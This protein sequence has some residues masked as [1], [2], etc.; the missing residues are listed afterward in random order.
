MKPAQL[1]TGADNREFFEALSHRDFEPIAEISLYEPPRATIDPDKTKSWVMRSWPIVRSHRTMW[2]GSMMMS[3][4][5]LLT[6]VQIP[7]ILGQAIN[8]LHISGSLAGENLGILSQFAVMLVI[9]I[10]VREI[11]NYTGR[12]MLLTTAY[13][14]EYDLRNNVYEHYM[15]LSFPFYDSVQIGQLISRA[16]S[17]VRSVQQYLVMAPTVFVQCAVVLIAFAEMFMINIPLT[18]V[19]M[20][21]LPITLAVGIIMRKKIF[22]VSWVIQAR[23]AE[24]ATI[25]EENISGVRV[26]KSFAAEQPELSALAGTADRLRWAYIKDADIRGTWA[27]T[28]ENLPR[29]GLAIILLYGGILVIHGHMGVGTLFT[30]Q[31]YMLLFQP[32]F[33]QL[34]MIIMNGQRASASAKRI[35]EVLD[36]QPEIVDRKDARDLLSC[37]G[38]VHF[39]DVSFH[40]A[41][42]TPV[43]R[44]FDL[45][46]TPGE[47]VALVGRT[48]S[49]KSTVARLLNRSYDVSEGAITIDGADIRDFTIAS[50]RAN[51]GI[52]LDEPFLFSVSIRDNIAYGRPDATMDEVVAAAKAADAHGFISRLSGGYE[53]IVGERGYT[54]SGGQRQRIA[55]ARTLLLNPPVLVLDDATS[56]ID[57]QVEQ[58]IHHALAGLLENRTTIIIA[59][60]LATISLADRVVLVENGTV[61]ASGPHAQLLANDRR[62]AEVLARVLEKEGEQLDDFGNRAG[63]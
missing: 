36:H 1:L 57:V 16:N 29:V 28:L 22:P 46:V 41:D 37:R 30:F 3:F 34:G 55:I 61:I 2:I 10:V 23:L 33:R 18:L 21:S 58:R 50:L 19:T 31:A 24:V 40:Y 62:Y 45:V 13:E 14:F 17:D 43:L 12:R 35:Y 6:Q 20:L 53:S 54:L 4:I 56:A 39:R 60:R 32:P 48:G 52:V 5:A 11:S 38:D 27:P 25:V 47:T 7:K 42:G 51:V 15:G 59:H 44:H 8:K 49:G 26:V 9:L 63:L